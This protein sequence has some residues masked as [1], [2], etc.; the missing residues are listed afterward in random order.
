M[1][2]PPRKMA[3]SLSK[4]LCRGS[5]RGTRAA[6][7]RSGL[8]TD[9]N[10]GNLVGMKQNVQVRWSAVA[11]L[12]WL[13]FGGAA[14]V[15]ADVGPID[16]ARKVCMGS[17]AGTP[18]SYQGNSGTCQGLHVSRMYCV[19]ITTTTPEPE[20]TAP[21]DAP[22]KAAEP[23]PTPVTPTPAPVKPAPVAPPAKK[24]SG[25]AASSSQQL[26]SALLV[27]GAI[28]IVGVTGKRR[29]ASAERRAHR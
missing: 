17:P 20:P 24:K 15:H 4:T 21:I 27:I 23:A 10:Q 7:R 28:G 22:V 26:P 1:S 12:T 13:A 16:P 25:C 2:R 19:P 11:I 9:A 6:M 3:A 5:C 29:R 8:Y 18:C 14:P